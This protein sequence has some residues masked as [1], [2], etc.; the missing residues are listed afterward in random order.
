MM[1]ARRLRL[2]VAGL[3]A[4]GLFCTA[5]SGRAQ[6]NDH[7]VY[8]GEIVVT[9]DVA[10]DPLW[11]VVLEKSPITPIPTIPELIKGAEADVLRARDFHQLST[12]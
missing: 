4:V 5:D 2:L 6:E 12:T 8:I 7:S 10:E 9:S 1:G 11:N 3:I